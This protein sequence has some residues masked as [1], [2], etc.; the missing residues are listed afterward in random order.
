MSNTP[1]VAPIDAE[2]KGS[3]SKVLSSKG[4]EDFAFLLAMLHQDVSNRL[5]LV[6]EHEEVVKD[7][8][9]R[10]LSSID[11]YPKIP[12]S[13]EKKH[14]QQQKLVSEAMSQHDVANARLMS[15]MFPPPLSLNNDPQFIP[16]DVLANC[17]IFCQRR[18]QGESAPEI[19]IDETMLADLIPQSMDIMP[20]LHSF[21]L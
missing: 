2:F 20:E 10:E 9:E 15:C 18:M 12:L 8:R 14:W 11:F 6:N 19:S 21:Q 17:D 3:F 5:N 13:T 7:T 16:E 1:H 4:A